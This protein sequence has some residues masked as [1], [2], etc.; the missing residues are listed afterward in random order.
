MTS[1]QFRQLGN[2]IRMAWL[3]KNRV[4]SAS[5]NTIN[6]ESIVH[7]DTFVGDALEDALSKFKEELETCID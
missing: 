3:Q 7:S 2:D 5:S 1:A 4:V 6:M